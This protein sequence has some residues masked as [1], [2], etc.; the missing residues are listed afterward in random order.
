MNWRRQLVALLIVL[1][2]AGCA[3]GTTVQTGAPYPAHPPEANGNMPEHGGGN[4]G[5][6]G[7]GM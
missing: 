3:Q 5:G 1:P 4:G 2:L 6:G 7:A